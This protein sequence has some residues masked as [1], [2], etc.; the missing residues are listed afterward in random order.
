MA[1]LNSCRKG[2][3][4]ELEAAKWLQEYLDPFARRGA[5]QGF[6]GSCRPDID[7]RLDLHIECKVVEKLNIY[8]AYD[9]AL[10]DCQPGKTPLVM[11]KRNRGQWHITFLATDLFT[12][13]DIVSRAKQILDEEAS[14]SVTL[15]DA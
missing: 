11:H 6:G 13:S 9:Q 4:G 5:S 7:T 10:R 15:E 1:K 14:Q 3:R 8:K 12:V 2:K